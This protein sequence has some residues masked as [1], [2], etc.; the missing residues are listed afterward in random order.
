MR[1]CIKRFVAVCRPKSKRSGWGQI[2]F[3]FHAPNGKKAEKLV[4][5]C[6][7]QVSRPKERFKVEVMEVRNH[8]V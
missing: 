8:V 4:E 2:Q 7:R 3:N 5:T 6:L 1:R